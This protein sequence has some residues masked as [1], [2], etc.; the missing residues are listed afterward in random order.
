[1]LSPVHDLRMKLQGGKSSNFISKYIVDYLSIKMI[2]KD[3]SMNY[4]VVAVDKSYKFCITF[5]FVR[6]SYEKNM[7]L[8]YVVKKINLCVDYLSIK[9]ISNEKKLNYKVV[10]LIKS[11][12]FNIKFISIP[13]YNKL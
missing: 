5:I 8:R 2:W 4:K 11:Y 6:V 12:H 3:K 1:M 7:F 9:M 13:I 10:N